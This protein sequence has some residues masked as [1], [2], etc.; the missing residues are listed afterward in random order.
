MLLIS[1]YLRGVYF[2]KKGAEKDV[3]LESFAVGLARKMDV[4]LGQ[5]KNQ[6][7]T[8]QYPLTE[9][10]PGIKDTH[11]I[12]E[13]GRESKQRHYGAAASEVKSKRRL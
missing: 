7:L 11:L 2:V 13:A 6:L 12:L 10:Y 9:Q 3:K 1:T 4:R 5:F 8:Q